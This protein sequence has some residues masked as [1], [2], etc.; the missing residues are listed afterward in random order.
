M[1]GIDINRV[2]LPNENGVAVTPVML[3]MLMYKTQSEGERNAAN[4]PTRQISLAIANKLMQARTKDE[5]P[6]YILIHW[7][8]RGLTNLL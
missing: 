5:N 3:S 2:S 8:S 6:S 1:P 7:G 4:W